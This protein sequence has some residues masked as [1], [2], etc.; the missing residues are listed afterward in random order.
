[1]RWSTFV[2]KKIPNIFSLEKNAP[3]TEMEKQQL[4]ILQEYKLQDTS[5]VYQLKKLNFDKTEI[6]IS[7]HEGLNNIFR[8]RKQEGDLLVRACSAEFRDIL[9]FR[10]NTRIV[11][12]AKICFSCH[13]SYFWK[14]LAPCGAFGQNGEF[15]ELK[16]LLYND[17]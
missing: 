8:Y 6:P 15:D 4:K 14:S 3:L 10:K 11:G 5:L 12:I 13:K 7:K 9:V 1:M 16:A 17:G 2:L